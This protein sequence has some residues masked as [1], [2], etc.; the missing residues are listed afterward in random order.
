MSHL[1]FANKTRTS[2][3]VRLVSLVF[4]MLI[5]SLSFLFH[6]ANAAPNYEINY[7][8]KLLNASSQA[9]ANDTYNMRFWLLTSPSIA[10]TSAI[11]TETLTGADKVQVTNGL[12]SVMLG[13]TTPLDGV[14]FNQTLYLGVEIGGTST[15]AWD[16]EM[17]P[18]KILGAV[19]AAF[20]AS[21]SSNVGGVA[22]TSLLR[23]DQDDTASGLITFT[24]GII[25]NSSSTIT[26]LTS[27]IATTTDLWLGGRFYDASNSAGQNGYILQTSGSQTTWVATSSLGFNDHASVTLAGTPDYLTLSGQEITLNQLDLADDLNTFT[28]SALLGRLTDETGTGFAV[29]S[30]SPTFTG[31]ALFASTSATFASSTYASSTSFTLFGS[32]FDSTQSAGVNGYVLQTS[33]SGVSWVATSS[34]GIGGGSSLW[35]QN[36]SDIYYNTGGV[37]IGTSTPDSLLSLYDTGLTGSVI[38]GERQYLEFANSTLNA[39]YYGDNAYIVNA[40]TATSTLVGKIIRIED[41]SA[42]GNVVRGLEVQ[43]QKGT[44]IKGEN[45]ALSGFARTFGVRGTTEGDA[46]E[47]ARP[48]GVFAET[49]GTDQGNA[50]RAYS[51]SLTTEDLVSFLHETEDFEGTMLSIDAG[52]DGGKFSST[53]S[54]FIE[55]K[56]GG[57]TQLAIKHDGSM[58]IGSSS[59]TARLTIAGN[60]GS[61]T[62]LFRIAS[63]TGS[64]ILIV[65]SRGYVGV[66]TTT[67]GRLFSVAGDIL[68]TTFFGTTFTGTNASTTYASTTNL[69][70]YGSL[71]DSSESAGQ[72]GYILQTTGSGVTWVATSSLGITSGAFTS[73]GGYTTLSS[74]SDFVGIG[75]STPS[76]RLTIVGTAGSSADLFRIASSTGTTTFA[77]SALGLT[78]IQP[79]GIEKIGWWTGGGAGVGAVYVNDDVLYMAQEYGGVRI[80][81]ISDKVGTTTQLAQYDNGGTYVDLDHSGDYLYVA[82]WS[83]GLEIVDVSDSQNPV[84]VATYDHNNASDL[85]VV[86]IFGNH[87]YLG[88]DD[89]VVNIFDAS[90][91]GDSITLLGTI[92]VGGAV[93]ELNVTGNF[94]YVSSGSGLIVLDVSDP[95]NPVQ[96]GNVNVTGTEW[97]SEIVGNYIYLTTTS[98]GL[99]IFDI[100]SPRNPTEVGNINLGGSNY[101]VTVAGDYAYVLGTLGIDIIDVSS[102]TNPTLFRHIADAGTGGQNDIIIDGNYLYVGHSTGGL[103]IYNISGFS[104]P[105]AN[106]GIVRSN[107]TVTESLVADVGS[108]KSTINVGQNALIGGQLAVTGNSSTTLTTNA[109]QLVLGGSNLRDSYLS[110]NSRNSSTSLDVWSIGLDQ[111]DDSF[112]ISSST[113]LGTRDYFSILKDGKVGIGTSTPSRLLTVAGDIFSTGALIGTSASTTYASTTNLSLYGSLYDSTASAGSN[114]YILQTTGAGTAW[115]ATS[116]LG[117]TASQWTTNGSDIYFNTGN[118]GIGS[119][120]PNAKLTVVGTAGSLEDTFRIASSTGS[121]TLAV[122][123]GGGLSLYQVNPIKLSGTGVTGGTRSIAKKGDHVY[124]GIVESAVQIYSIATDTPSYVGSIS[125][126]ETV[127]D[128]TVSGDYLYVSN[129]VTSSSSV[130]IFDIS[131][132][133]SPE[134][135]GS[136]QTSGAPRSITISGQY[137]YV[138]LSNSGST[139]LDI[140]DISN[141][142]NPVKVSTIDAGSATYETV[143]SGGYL[144]V[145]SASLGQDFEVFD[146][147]DPANPVETI[148]IGLDS[149]AQALDVS[150]DYAYAVGNSELTIIDISDKNNVFV[151]STSSLTSGSNFIAVSGN[152]AFITGGSGNFEVF[153]ITDPFNP[154]RVAHTNNGGGTASGIVISGTRA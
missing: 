85:E 44:N 153:D 37:G 116:S 55:L 7:Q 50:L 20:Y 108:F 112:K 35:T 18:R 81:D 54:R 74:A 70:L 9:V 29:F 75:S 133:D 41:N 125:T 39:V 95:T 115:I 90:D 143:V 89:G 13:S 152:Y 100:S 76:S 12:F 51:S 10:T 97:G 107:R 71:F 96:V 64:D 102:T 94:A 137:A 128:L 91:R 22:S 14:D 77:V 121:T 33:G 141:P 34:L 117:I 93:H 154:Y 84:V 80:F 126:A 42:L 60:T 25:S 40:P 4:V 26:N 27:L 21:T 30:N 8:G 73:S 104:A 147:S 145:T 87:L 31:N 132:P 118:V 63:S 92:N 48:A 15:V 140:F 114:G 68:G 53:T 46:G 79:T 103:K 3:S 49:R 88:Y 17:S 72:N 45:T 62:N 139:N 119:T 59:P 52:N 38:G 113:T 82:N 2:F 122:D 56:N 99:F 1:K 142:S 19:P 11:W 148:G 36:G 66:G 98:N 127:G 67:P 130:Q 24:G 106:I 101:D 138:S 16:G 144:Y 120:S 110:F 135:V 86:K 149:A 146:I 123:Y 6:K 78:R 105:N 150:G 43:A 109:A 131:S 28:S 47:T 5:I 58:G 136:F 69:S 23:S 32:L 134:L 57:T 111:T 83:R 151:T 65:D 129:N 124:I 61:T